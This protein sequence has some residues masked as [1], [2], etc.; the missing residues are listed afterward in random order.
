MGD[1][2]LVVRAEVR[3]F[4]VC[5]APHHVIRGVTNGRYDGFWFDKLAV[6]GLEP[7]PRACTQLPVDQVDWHL[8]RVQPHVD[9]IRVRLVRVGPRREVHD[10]V[11]PFGLHVL[12]L[13]YVCRQVHA[14]EVPVRV[15]VDLIVEAVSG[16]QPRVL[17]RLVRD[18]SVGLQLPRAGLFVV[19]DS[20]GLACQG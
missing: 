16:Y 5:A 1:K 12:P 18:T 7:A 2:H 17:G 19:H 6:V 4:D 9:S 15:H 11:L 8:G 10:V 14:D 13:K 3:V 20:R